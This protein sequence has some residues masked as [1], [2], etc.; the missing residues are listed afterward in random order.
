MKKQLSNLFAFSL[1]TATTL[2]GT[3]CAENNVLPDATNGK[4]RIGDITTLQ[5]DGPTF[6]KAL[7][8][9]MNR[10]VVGYG[11]TAFQNGKVVAGGGGGWASKSFES[12]PIKHGDQQRQEIAGCGKFVTALTTAAMLEKYGMPLDSKVYPYLPVTWQQGKAMKEITFERLLAHQTG[13]INHGT[14]WDK[15]K[16]AVEEYDVDDKVGGYDNVNYRLMAIILVYLDIHKNK[17]LLPQ[18]L[19]GFEANPFFWPESVGN[20][21]TG[22]AREHVFK[23]A[24]LSFWYMVDYTTWDNNGAIS[25]ELGTKGYLSVVGNE[26]GMLKPDRRHDVGPGELYLSA[27]EFGRIQTAAATGKIVSDPYYEVMKT[28]RLGFDGAVSGAKGTYYWKKGSAAYHETI[29]FDMG[30]TQICVFANSSGSGIENPSVIA[31]IYE[32]AFIAK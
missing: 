23:P 29:L 17:E 24:G 3:G 16:K 15:L 26:P 32:K 27:N 5:F 11:Y 9:Y 18:Q 13:L 2:L 31:N 8:T 12:Y 25:A 30:Q 14:G 7:E 1:V 22:M 21:F 10:K 4:A 19:A 6:G 20:R 28:K